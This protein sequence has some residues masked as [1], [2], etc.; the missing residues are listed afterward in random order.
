MHDF[1]LIIFSLPV[2]SVTM[3][4]MEDLCYMFYLKALFPLQSVL[5]DMKYD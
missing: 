2:C 5:Y 1:S 4:V 3:K